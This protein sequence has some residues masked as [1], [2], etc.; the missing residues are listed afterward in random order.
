MQEKCNSDYMLKI[1]D[2]LYSN[3]SGVIE[4]PILCAINR[5]VSKPFFRLKYCINNPLPCQMKFM[6]DIHL[7][8]LDNEIKTYAE[9][10]FVKN[11]AK[12]LFSDFMTMENSSEVL[13]K[14]L[15]YLAEKYSSL[16]EAVF[17]ISLFDS[18]IEVINIFLN[19][20]KFKKV[21]SLNYYDIKLELE[22]YNRPNYFKRYADYYSG[23][24]SDFHN[25][26]L[27]QE[28]KLYFTK[29]VSEIES[30]YGFAQSFIMRNPENDEVLAV[31]RLLD[32]GERNY[33]LELVLNHSYVSFLGDIIK[34]VNYIL[35]KSGQEYALKICINSAY[36]N[37]KDLKNQLEESKFQYLYSK[38]IFAKDYLNRV[39]NS[40]SIEAFQLAFRD[41]NPAYQSSCEFQN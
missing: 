20:A 16:K 5:K 26:S 28:Q 17:Y 10:S 29:N 13:T 14:F 7:A 4:N 41:R 24:I 1:D 21:A 35:A 39:K 32:E 34:Y 12:I 18:D 9:L 22:N 27:R 15:S 31:F 3:L 19:D 11:T 23:Y 8:V 38:S 33:T 6:Q 2:F 30:E 37:F 36:Q 40:E 25:I